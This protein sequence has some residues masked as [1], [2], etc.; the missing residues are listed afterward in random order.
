MTTHGF[1]LTEHQ[2]RLV[3][4]VYG[5]ENYD[6][7]YADFLK[8]CNVL[9][10]IINGPFTGAKSTYQAKFTDFNGSSEL[11]NLME[12]IKQ[13]IKRERIRLLEFFQDHDLLRKGSVE[14]TKFRSVLHS[15]KV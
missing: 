4:L 5:E 10:Y 2:T 6:I 1:P 3:S 8:D 11:D 12:K 14:P 15:Q 7:R 13:I 9:V